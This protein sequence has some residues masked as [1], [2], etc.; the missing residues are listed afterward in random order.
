MHLLNRTIVLAL[1]AGALAG[2]NKPKA[3]PTAEDKIVPSAKLTADQLS[4]AYQDNPVAADQKFKG[5]PIEITGE[6][7][8]FG[9]LALLGDYVKLSVAKEGAMDVYCFFFPNDQGVKDQVAKLKKG[10]KVTLLGRCEGK[11]AGALGINVRDC[12]F[13]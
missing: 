13:P 10:Q 11:A 7:V 12:L 3:K 4:D 6:I 9:Q 8:D 1:V 5:K 2:C